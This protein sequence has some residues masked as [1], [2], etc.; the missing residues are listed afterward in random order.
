MR[1]VFDVAFF[2]VDVVAFVD[3]FATGFFVTAAFAVD[4]RD[5][6]TGVAD[7]SRLTGAGTAFGFGA[8]AR[9]CFIALVCSS[10]VVRNS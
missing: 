2:F 6:L 7:A 10:S 8:V 4:F 3:F 5:V 9:T 1:V